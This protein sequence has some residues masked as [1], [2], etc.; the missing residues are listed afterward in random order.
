MS[1]LNKPKIL[2]ICPAPRDGR[3]LKSLHFDKRYDFIYHDYSSEELEKLIYEE[4]MK[5][6]NPMISLKSINKWSKPIRK[7]P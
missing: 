2:V 4:A 3:K 5:R 1:V 7:Y 6:A